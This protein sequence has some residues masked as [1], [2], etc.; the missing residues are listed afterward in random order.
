VYKFP[1][2][3]KLE[4]H[5]VAISS[6]S[7]Y[8]SFFNFPTSYSFE[9]KFPTG[10]GTNTSTYTFTIPAGFY[11]ISD[12]NNV[13]I[14]QMIV[15]KLYAI[16]NNG[17]NH[18]FFELLVNS[19]S[20]A[21]QMNFY[22]TNQK[23]YTTTATST[24][25]QIPSGAGWTAG[26][27][28]TP[29]ITIPDATLGDVI[30]FSPATYGAY[31]TTKS[32]TSTLTPEVSLVNSLI[33]CCSLVNNVGISNPTNVLFSFPI[34]TSSYGNQ[35]GIQSPIPQYIDV[36][37]NTYQ[38]LSIWFLDQNLNR[39]SIRDTSV[40]IGLLIKEKDKYQLH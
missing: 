17:G 22:T 39:V 21:V 32:L 35:V 29:S 11:Q 7:I 33:V 2:Q 38:S 23:T 1:L 30:G 13:L 16:D 25:W 9:F 4:N 26:V 12:L 31:T 19:T 5:K 36:A 14:S 3:Q 27:A 15:N 34:P 6:V 28:L 20:Y 18:Y 24:T 8:N 10:T 37:Q 40:V